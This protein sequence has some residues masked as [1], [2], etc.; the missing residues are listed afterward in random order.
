VVGDLA[1][2]PRPDSTNAQRSRAAAVTVRVGEHL[3][4]AVGQQRTLTRIDD[5]HDRLVLAQSLREKRRD[6]IDQRP[7]FLVGEELVVGYRIR[8]RAGAAENWA[9]RCAAGDCGRL[10]RN[11]QIGAAIRTTRHFLSPAGAE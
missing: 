11:A 3:S 9:T 10:R 1:Y 4:G 6:A 8:T 5:K 7:V 2:E